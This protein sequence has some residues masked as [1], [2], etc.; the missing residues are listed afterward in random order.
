MISK[1]EYVVNTEK[2]EIQSIKLS[3]MQTKP[4]FFSQCNF[5]HLIKNLQMNYQ[6]FFTI[7]EDKIQMKLHKVLKEMKL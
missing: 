2:I 4:D 6:Q 1:S 5:D 3:L 7:E